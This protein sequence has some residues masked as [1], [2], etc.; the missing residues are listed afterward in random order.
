MLWC[1]I[2]IHCIKTHRLSHL[3]VYIPLNSNEEPL[4]CERVVAGGRIKCFTM[5]HIQHKAA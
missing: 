5:H 4:S 3:N 1:H 2:Y